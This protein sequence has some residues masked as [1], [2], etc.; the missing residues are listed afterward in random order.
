MGRLRT[1][2]FLHQAPDSGTVRVNHDQ[3]PAG[4]DTRRRLYVTRK[5]DGNVIAYCHNCSNS[6]FHGSGSRF[7]RHP[8]DV[9]LVEVE[10]KEL[11]MPE[12][13][14]SEQKDWPKEMAVWL[15]K[16][17]IPFTIAQEYG[18]CYDSERHRVVIPK[19]NKDGALVQYQSRRLVDDGS[20]KYLT[21][22]L[23][24]EHIH[25]PIGPGERT[26]IIVEDMISAIRLVLLGYDAVP[27][28][29]DTMSSETMLTLVG[30]Y[31]KIYVWLDNDSVTVNRHADIICTGLRLLD[32]HAQRITGLRDP[33]HY[34]DSEIDGIIKEIGG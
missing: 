33:K 13:M 28:F 22:K 23:K 10:E 9:S 21:N 2:E 34:K 3:C 7:R 11:V 1:N 31:D 5:E 16:C 26:C 14:R 29:T 6:G 20:P 27:L 15:I 30:R 12:Y 18:I 17:G 8:V 25:D 24:H 19:L 4:Q 32:Q